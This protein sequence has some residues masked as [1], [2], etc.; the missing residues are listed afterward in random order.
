[1]RNWLAWLWR[2]RSPMIS[3]LSGSQYL[4]L[5]QWCNLVWVWR[6]ENHGSWWYKSR[7]RGW[8][9]WA[10]M[11]QLQHEAEKT[12]ILPSGGVV[13]N[14]VFLISRPEYSWNSRHSSSVLAMTGAVSFRFTHRFIFRRFR[15]TC[16]NSLECLMTGPTWVDAMPHCAVE[17][18]MWSEEQAPGFPSVTVWFLSHILTVPH[19]KLGPLKVS[20]FPWSTSGRHRIM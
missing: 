15:D 16:C 8:R 17:G 6:S 10:E 7:C 1:M 11:S 9:R 14:F 13:G 20:S 3:Y 12:M 19:A 5:H 2:L 4:G 18:S